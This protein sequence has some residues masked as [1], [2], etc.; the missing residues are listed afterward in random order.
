M[1]VEVYEDLGD[2]SDDEDLTPSK[3]AFYL[4][5]HFDNTFYSWAFKYM[6]TF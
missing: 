4:F 1:T 2:F 6:Y 5:T 3:I